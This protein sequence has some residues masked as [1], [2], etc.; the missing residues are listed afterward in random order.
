MN[1]YLIK[2][3]TLVVERA[4][5]ALV[6]R[7][8]VTAQDEEEARAL[9]VD[10]LRERGA[11]YIFACMIEGVNPSLELT[12]LEHRMASTEPFEAVDPMA[13]DIHAA[14]KASNLAKSLRE[15]R[16]ELVLWKWG[17]VGL[18]ALL[19]IVLGLAC[20]GMSLKAEN[21]QAEK[22]ILMEQAR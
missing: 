12:V 1:Q 14:A 2:T 6:D 20:Y 21:D 11:E 13:F 4:P 17:A 18:A 3:P 5:Y 8:L 22:T 19:L 10:A 16:R 15:S 7:V 9:A